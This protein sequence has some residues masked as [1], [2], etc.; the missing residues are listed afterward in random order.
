MNRTD[1]VIRKIHND[2]A[3]CALDEV[4]KKFKSTENKSGNSSPSSLVGEEEIHTDENSTLFLERILKSKRVYRN[5][6]SNQNSI[7]NLISVN[8]QYSELLEH[9]KLCEYHANK[10]KELQSKSG[11]RNIIAE[12]YKSKLTIFICESDVKASQDQTDGAGFVDLFT[13]K[14]I[15]TVSTIIERLENTMKNKAVKR[16]F[17]GIL[18][19]E[20]SDK[21]NLFAN[22]LH[23][24]VTLFIA[25]FFSLE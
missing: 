22:I 13:T 18:N 23:A 14:I 19:T 25:S 9:P 4:S 3:V 21:K 20:A 2:C 10:F 8:G 16:N 11:D 1:S 7:E 15:P 5:S 6:T 17:E 24:I 12:F